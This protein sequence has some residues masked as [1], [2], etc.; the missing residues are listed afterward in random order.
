MAMYCH[1]CGCKLHFG[2]H[3]ETER[4]RCDQIAAT[5]KIAEAVA[6]EREACA[7]MLEEMMPKGKA[8]Q[9][10][11]DDILREAVLEEAAQAIRAR[12]ND[13]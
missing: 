2:A 9:M 11:R 13:V 7:V 12:S 3:T 1:N 5:E 8:S 4:M 10:E 6:A